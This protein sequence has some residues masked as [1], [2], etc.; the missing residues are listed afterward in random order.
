LAAIW[1]RRLDRQLLEAVGQGET[2][3]VVA[4]LEQGADVNAS[5]GYDSALSRAGRSP[6][7]NAPT[8]KVLLERGADLRG[9]PPGRGV[10]SLIRASH[11]SDDERILLLVEHGAE[12]NIVQRR[13]PGKTPLQESIGWAHLD[14]IRLLL[15][16]G[17][18]PK[19]R[20][21]YVG[22]TALHYAVAW[23]RPDAVRLLLDRN[24]PVLAGTVDRR[25]P[26]DLACEMLAQDVCRTDSLSI[27]LATKTRAAIDLLATVS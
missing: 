4:L 25:T 15:D 11:A 14:T 13:T 8:L 1:Q 19:M 9:S 5:D 21:L 26:L 18:N 23:H 20:S 16:R 27:E 7:S 6:W 22:W 3:A 17:S 12:L 24:V 10:N 2:A